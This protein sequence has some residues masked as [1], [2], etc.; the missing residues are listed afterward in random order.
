MSQYNPTRRDV[1]AGAVAL[2][3]TTALATPRM[4]LAGGHLA[5]Q[6]LRSV[7]LSVTVQDRILNAFK[8]ESGVGSV[9]GKADLLPNTQ[10]ELL[11]GSSAY[12][13]WETTGERLPA[14]TVTSTIKP[15]P[16]S[17][18]KNWSN[19]RPTFTDI[20][21]RM[22]ERAQIS[23]QIWADEARTELWMVPTV[24]N[25]DS[26]GYRPDLV[27]AE[28]ASTWTSLFDPKFKGKTGLNVDPLVA[29]GQT[30]LAM[31]ALGMLENEN[32]GNPSIVE[33]DEAA[34]FL[35]SKKREG[36]FRALWGD[37][38]ELVDLLASGDMVLADA[39]QP[40][41]LAVKARG[42][43]CSYAVPAEGYRAW[44][45]GNALIAN[46]PNAEAVIAYSDYWLSGPPAIAV[47]EQGY[48]S[49]TTNIR[50]V[51]DAARY[52]FWYEGKPWV[53]APDRGIQE[54]DLRDGGSLEE[55]A[56]HVRY[57]HQWPDHYDHLISKW[58]DF[59][60]A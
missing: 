29:F 10:T 8:E 54:G 41:V 37:I 3:A 57:W 35:V 13:V 16:I 1:M 11:S 6:E 27:S 60:S 46:S 17:A 18:L 36:Q 30:V 9:S 26:I 28:E 21:P 44:S 19:I 4:V 15:I 43:P 14:M 12:D 31:T 47:S 45:V 51:M 42:V 2:G 39:W 56:S 38:A 52:D 55:R 5:D 34:R 22:E 25:F 50:D 20:D 40:A 53:G 32:P 48:Y 49:P 59:L 58:D 7:G 24:Y 23:G 33:I